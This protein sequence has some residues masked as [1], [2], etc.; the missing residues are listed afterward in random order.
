[1]RPLRIFLPAALLITVLMIACGSSDSDKS[2]VTE[3]SQALAAAGGSEV[4]ASGFL[5]ADRDGLIRLCSLLL[6]S[7]PPQCG[8]D[9]IELPGFD[10][11][12]VPDTQRAQVTND[13]RTLIWTN[14]PI[15]V[16]GIRTSDGLGSAQ[17]LRGN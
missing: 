13:I 12:S 2:G 14:D 17:L 4:S 5:I 7:S 16:T 8:G 9:R 11:S 15:T 1:M 10:V 6:E 3:I